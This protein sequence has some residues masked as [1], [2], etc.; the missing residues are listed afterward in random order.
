M[1]RLNQIYHTVLEYLSGG[2]E[3]NIYA[4][5]SQL[6][7]YLFVIGMLII[8]ASSIYTY[9][10][11]ERLKQQELEQMDL[12]K[13]GQELLGLETLDN[14]AIPTEVA[15]FILTL[16]SRNTN[17]PVIVT[18]Y[19]Y[20]VQFTKNIEG[21]GDSTMTDEDKTKATKIL[22][23]W[24]KQGRRPIQIKD[25]YGIIT[26]KIYF[27]DSNNLTLLKYYPFFQFFLIAFFIGF[28]YVAFSTAR[29]SEQNQVWVGMAKETA[30]Q[31]GTPIAAILG[32]IEHLRTTH[33]DDEMTQEV[34]DELQNDVNRLSLVADRFSK[35]GSAP[36]LIPVNVYEELDRC[37]EYMQKRSPRKVVFDFPIFKNTEGEVDK[38]L[39]AEI[40]SHLFDWVIENLLR[41]ALDAMEGGEGKITA[42]IYE[43]QQWVCIDIT[44][45]GKGIPK[46]KF[47][48]VFQ[49]GFTTKKRGWGLGLSLAKRIIENYHGGK[50]LVKDSE[51]GKFTTFS[52]KLPFK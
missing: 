51:L 30:H 27:S 9:F 12:Y 23:T 13:S 42:T 16:P 26:N 34:V 1:N 49:P 6:K 40:N 45:T 11:V 2:G 31:L 33:E 46:N 43:E 32:W 35:I 8:S 25:Q 22:N 4:L 15:N 19:G 21:V 52:I 14:E 18:D 29:R 50:I 20:D 37:R 24:I 38:Y 10:L 48:T 41:N 44:D 47:H 39:F 28:G 5:K 17:I 7:I 36:E 3:D